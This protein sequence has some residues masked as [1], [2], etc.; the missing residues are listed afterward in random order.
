[1]FISAKDT[2]RTIEK[3]NNLKKFDPSIAAVIEHI[4]RDQCL[5]CV[6]QFHC[7]AQRK[8]SVLEKVDQQSSVSKICDDYRLDPTVCCRFMLQAK[9]AHPEFKESV[10]NCPTTGKF[11]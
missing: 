3:I 4:T 2:N 10:L 5:F 11:S 7:T 8:R 6:C 9:E 1:M